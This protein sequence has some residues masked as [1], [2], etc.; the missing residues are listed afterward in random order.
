MSSSKLGI[1]DP[2]TG[3]LTSAFTECPG[4][5]QSCAAM[6]K[7]CNKY[8]LQKYYP[9]KNLTNARDEDVV[10]QF[11]NAVVKL[12]QN[13]RKYDV[14]V[15]ASP[16]LSGLLQDVVKKNIN[17][18]S[19]TST[20]NTSAQVVIA[21]NLAYFK[22]AKLISSNKRI[23]AFISDKLRDDLLIN[24]EKAIEGSVLSSNEKTNAKICLKGTGK[25]VDGSTNCESISPL[26]GSAVFMDLSLEADGTT[27]VSA[28]DTIN[29]LKELVLQQLLGYITKWINDNYDVSSLRVTG[30]SEDAKRV[31]TALISGTMTEVEKNLFNAFFLVVKDDKPVAI[32][33]IDGAKLDEYR[34]NCRMG[35]FMIDSKDKKLPIVVNYI[36]VLTK[37]ARV[38]YN[39]GENI[40][41]AADATELLRQIF[42]IA[43]T[44]DSA[45]LVTALAPVLPSFDTTSPSDLQLDIQYLIRDI[46][47]A[48]NVPHAHISESD[49]EKIDQVL[50]GIWTRTGVNT[51]KHKL[52]D[53]SIVRL[54]PGTSAFDEE[55]ASEIQNCSAV[56][57]SDDAGKCAEFFK[58]VGLSNTSELAKLATTMTNEV[59]ASAVAKLHPR[60]ALSI[61]KTFGFHKK[62]C[63]DKVAGRK[64]HKVQTVQEW[65]EK[66]VDKHFKDSSVATNIKGNERLCNFLNLLT[67]LVNGNPS[68]LNEEMVDVET[69]ESRGETV[70]PPELA[71]RK[72]SA[73]RSKK[74]GTPVVS[75][76]NIQSNMNKVY[77]SFSKGLTFDGMSSNAPF[78]MDNLFP[79]MSMLTSAP[80][81][82]SSTWGSM[83]G[84]G[85][86]QKTFLQDHETGFEYSRN[87]GKIIM[88]LI[89]N[90]KR[91]S[92]KTLTT[93]EI[94]SIGDKLARFEDLERELYET[95]VNIQKYSQLLKIVEAENKPEIITVSHVKQYVDKYNHLMTRYDKTG[96]SF[97]TLISLLKD[98]CEGGEGGE[99]CN[100]NE[101]L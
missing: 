31:L 62:V 74:S 44:N 7:I 19:I 4:G 67:Q 75:W 20:D 63:M 72:I 93:E 1:F 55:I 41:P 26:S 17:E 33:E 61:L 47:S 12:G 8:F 83:A 40:S 90:L 69:E 34:L 36:P 5:V 88:V 32:S 16:S 100:H 91:N 22:D 92:N 6:D 46:V 29:S 95:A 77:G 71:E 27:L 45:S 54:N 99:N 78:G 76:G 84:G 68:V 101:P 15:G 48:S 86:V 24:M 64:M 10:A 87:V 79:Q 66:F 57:F 58:N 14:S 43:Y 25:K 50:K 3:Y 23:S 52:S 80:V 98:C 96:S 81:V 37:M 35:N 9:S 82:R 60:L 97:N 30:S 39:K 53:G 56:G 70:V 49:T 65:K 89:D 38:R 2:L 59:T 94:K 73:A 85:D 18:L 51:W 42:S 21:L 11:T 28:S 13:L